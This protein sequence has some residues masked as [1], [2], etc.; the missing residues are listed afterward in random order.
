[1]ADGLEIHITEAIAAGSLVATAT[2]AINNAVEATRATNVV[3]KVY[4]ALDP[5]YRSKVIYAFMS[6]NSFD[7]L[8]DDIEESQKYTVTDPSTNQVMPNAVYV[9]GTNRRLIA[10]GCGWMGASNRIIVTPKENVVIGCD[11][12]SDANQINTKENLW[13]REMGLLFNVGVNFALMD[14]VR[15]ND[16][17]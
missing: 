1:M 5:G 13:T 15:I 4:R 2:G 7:L 8:N 17:A 12:L 3:K 16:Q 6:F 10:V 11:L 9:P 14:A